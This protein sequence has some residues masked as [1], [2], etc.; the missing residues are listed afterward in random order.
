MELLS[1]AFP[2]EWLLLCHPSIYKLLILLKYLY[3]IFLREGFF[4]SVDYMIIFEY[5]KII[6]TNISG[7]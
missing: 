1:T 2:R 5:F 6:Y 7:F 4:G 3:F